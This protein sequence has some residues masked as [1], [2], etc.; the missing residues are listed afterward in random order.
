MTPDEIVGK[1]LAA[2]GVA[3][4]DAVREV[5]S[6]RPKLTHDPL[7]LPDMEA[8][9]DFLS[10]ALRA[11]RRVCVYGDY[12]VDGVCG[13]ALLVGFLRAFLRGNMAA[14]E[15]RVTYY[16]PNRIEEGYGLNRGA[17]DAIRARGD[18]VVVTV[19]CGSVSVAE[20]AYAKEIGLDIVITDHHEMDAGG[21][22]PDCL[23]VNPKRPGSAYPF[24][25]LCGAAVAF[26]LCCAM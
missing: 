9:A 25:G 24:A 19:D 13:T 21:A 23:V 10:G 14:P 11:G 7:L 1:V 5:L 4:E 15:P 18:E 20:A 6:P 17:L 22:A 2:R 26:K 16:I 8:A 12:D 3:R